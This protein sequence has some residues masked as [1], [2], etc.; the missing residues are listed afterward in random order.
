MCK[1][2]QELNFNRVEVIVHMLQTLVVHHQDS[3]VLKIPPPILSRVFQTLSRGQV[4]LANCKKI[5]STLFPFPY[6]QMIAVLLVCYMIMTPVVMGCLC[7]KAHWAFIFTLLPVFG[8]CSLNYIS[9]ELEMPFGQDYNDLPLLEFQEHMNKSMLMLIHKEVDH[10]PHTSEKCPHDFDDCKRG[11]STKRPRHFLDPQG[12]KPVPK[13]VAQEP[14]Q[15]PKLPEPV[16][17]PEPQ[18]PAPSSLEQKIAS[19]ESAIHNITQVLVEC[20]DRLGTCTCANV[21]PI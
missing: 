19:L 14:K 9:R 15:V 6:A 4:N 13:Q 2:D 20:A 5:T 12:D 11:I 8:T 10:V 17:A 16:K 3:G 21:R 18:L 1:F 7:E